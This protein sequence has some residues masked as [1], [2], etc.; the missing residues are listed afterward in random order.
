MKT[1]LAVAALG[2]ETASASAIIPHTL[3]RGGRPGIKFTVE[4]Y[5]PS[6][7]HGQVGRLSDGQ[8]RIGGGRPKGSYIFKDGKV[9]DE[10]GHGCILTPETAQWQC[11]HNTHREF[12]FSPFNSKAL[13]NQ[14]GQR[15]MA[16]A[17]KAAMANFPTTARTNTTLALSTITANG[18]STQN[19]LL[20]NSSAFPSP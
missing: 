6:S 19:P 4:A 1:V 15:P 14:H 3:P 10:Q 16:S 13:A 9:W 7:A 11:D 20:D 8:N 2:L 12:V 5:G 18:T 17:L